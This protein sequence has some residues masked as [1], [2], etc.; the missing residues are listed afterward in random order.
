[1]RWNVLAG[2]VRLATL[3]AIALVAVLASADPKTAEYVEQ[4]RR[5]DDYRVRTQ[6]ALALGVSGDEAALQPLCAALGAEGHVAVKVAVAAA[7]GRLGKPAGLPCLKDALAKESVASV[8][9][10]IQKSVATLEAIAIA[11]GPPPPPGP[12]S[13]FYV[14]ID[15]TNKTAR[16]PDEVEALV[17]GAIQAKLLGS[18]GF[19]VA[20]RGETPAQGGSI[21]KAKKLKGFFLLAAVEAP[22]YDGATLTQVVRVSAWTYPGKSLTGEFSQRLT[23]SDTPTVDVQS[24][25][26]LMKQ[27]AESAVAAFQQRVSQM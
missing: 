12:D 23:Q 21:V 1:M 17:R 20:P 27:C 3:L 9:A 6:A 16:K 2:V 11:N 14:A 4:L 10:Q 15:V 5:N 18:P 24:E 7:L 25:T 19:A 22:V 8:K 26:A 13:R